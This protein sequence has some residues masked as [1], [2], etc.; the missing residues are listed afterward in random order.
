MIVAKT[1]MKEI[2]ENCKE[3]NFHLCNIPLTKDGEHIMKS[4]IKKRHKCCPLIKIENEREV[5][6]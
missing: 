4:C 2:P 6:R 1:H 3:C 5:A